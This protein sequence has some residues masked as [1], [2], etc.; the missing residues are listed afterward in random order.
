MRQVNQVPSNSRRVRETQIPLAGHS[1]D[2]VVRAIQVSAEILHEEMTDNKAM[3]W[4]E[5]LLYEPAA[6]VVWAFE[7]WTKSAD[8]F[9]KPKDILGLIQTWREMQSVELCGLCDGGWVISNPEAKRS[10][11]K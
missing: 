7:K 9:P 5:L 10:D 11:Q 2:Q 3:Y 1:A 4:K 8:F 6:G